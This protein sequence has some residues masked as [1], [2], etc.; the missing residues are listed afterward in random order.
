MEPFTKVFKKKN[1]NN[2][3][4]ETL[5][6]SIDYEKSKVRLKDL[7]RCVAY[8]KI[9]MRASCRLALQRKAIEEYEWRGFDSLERLIK[10]ADDTR[11]AYERCMKIHYKYMLALLNSSPKT[12]NH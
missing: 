1:M 4:T 9:A 11:A 5:Q 7:E 3:L 12:L 2:L 10:Q 8:Q 6:A